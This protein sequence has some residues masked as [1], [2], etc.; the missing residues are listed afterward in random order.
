MKTELHPTQA[1]RLFWRVGGV[2]A[3]I[4]V[5]SLWGLV[6][7]AAAQNE[8]NR[9][10]LV[11]QFG[12]GSVYTAC[13]DLGIDGQSTGEE[14]LRDS[15]LPV[16]IDYSSGYGDGTVCK[17]LD[18]GCDF[19]GEKC[20]C[21]CTMKPGDP[22]IYWIFFHQVAEE[23]RYSNQGVKGH[24]VRAGDVEGWVWGAG[25][26]QDGVLPQPITFDQICN[27]SGESIEATVDSERT[28]PTPPPQ[29]AE[30]PISDSLAKPVEPSA[31]ATRA[32]TPTFKVSALV[33]SSAT[34][35]L[36]ANIEQTPQAKAQVVMQAEDGSTG[37]IVT[38][39]FPTSPIQILETDSQSKTSYFVFGLL[40]IV[41]AGGLVYL[42]T[43]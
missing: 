16:I 32:A 26:S 15:G 43:R 19:P 30:T 1:A 10:G 21:Q 39:P 23:W 6:R 35:A 33:T 18:E 27:A 37:V 3:F 5:L 22:C 29:P 24:A 20:F 38:Q 41:L 4:L 36:G 9:A 40:V 2:A 8:D 12:D 25:S 11:I 17:I 31:A 42:R 7:Q 14:M 34:P 13:V 28:S